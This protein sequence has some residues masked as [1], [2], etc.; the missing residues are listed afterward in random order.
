M[1]RV[2]IAG[3]G[4]IARRLIAA[5]EILDDISVT[6]ALTHRPLASVKDMGAVPLT[7]SVNEL[8]DR[9]DVI[10]ECSGHPVRAADVVR[11]ALDAELPVVTMNSEF[12]VTCGSYFVGKGDLTEAHG[13]QPGVQAALREELVGMGFKPLVYGNM[14][15]FLNLKPT[16]DDM[17]YWSKRQGFRV[18]Q[19]TSFTDGTKVQMEQALV[20]NAFDADIARRGLLAPQADSFEDAID[21]LAA[22]AVQAG[23]PIADFSVVAGQA[24]GVFI[25]ATIDESQRAVLDA[26]KMG[27][28]PYYTFVRPFHLCALEIPNTIRRAARGE[29]SL[30]DNSRCPRI[31][32][33]AVAKRPLEP[34][35]R[36]EA[37]IG[38]FEV[39]GEALR[40]IDEPDHVPMGLMYD[41]TVRRHV[42]PGQLIRIDDVELPDSFARDITLDLVR[43]AD[44]EPLGETA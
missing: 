40:F 14:K 27:K 17:V 19:T 9:A 3:T 16:H 12:H 5:G 24:P 18:C 25:I 30:L 6:C 42:E 44:P 33:G 10:V 15:G 7:N 20:A 28:G 22:A 29:P 23:G 11:D 26:L 8:I 39:R 31:G 41:V 4:F 13:D 35:D 1:I 36:I 43:R 32:V 21:V 34:G 2:G 38:S 37:G